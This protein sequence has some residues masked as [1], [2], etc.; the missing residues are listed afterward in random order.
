MTG[1]I[2]VGWETDNIVV[3]CETGNIAGSDSDEVEAATGTDTG[4]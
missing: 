2:A 1:N 4:T 3:G